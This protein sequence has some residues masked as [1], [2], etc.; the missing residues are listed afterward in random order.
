MKPPAYFYQ[1]EAR[2]MY[3]ALN[4]LMNAAPDPT[5][6][7]DALPHYRQALEQARAALAKIK[8]NG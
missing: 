3:D 2:L 6:Y 7:D 8:M 5:G 1:Y 4:Q